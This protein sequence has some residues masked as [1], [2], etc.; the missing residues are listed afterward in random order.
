LPREV[1]LCEVTHMA[2]RGRERRLTSLA[3]LDPTAAQ[4][5]ILKA[6]KECNGHRIEVAQKLGIARRTLYELL[7]RLNL[8]EEV[9][10]RW[11]KGGRASDS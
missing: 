1:K 2:Q 5:E 6:F 4:K 7:H 8:T 9:T 11:P 10:A 3:N